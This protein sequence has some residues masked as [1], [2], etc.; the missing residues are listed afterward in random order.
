MYE[1]DTIA[2]IATPPGPGGIGVIRVSGAAAEQLAR[3]VAPRRRPADAWQSHRLYRVRLC[4]A[5][6]TALDDGMAVLMRAPHS[7]TG[8]D[9]LE[10]HAHGSPVVL[11]GLLS[12][13]LELGARPARAGEFTQ[14]AFLNGKLDLAQAEAVMALV[15]ARTADG[16]AAAAGQLF[17]GLSA[18]CAA[19]RACL[20]RARAH[21]E[22]CLDFG[23][24]GLGIDDDALAVELREA[25]AA[26]RELLAG[27]TR[28]ELVRRG[29]RV[30]ITGRPNAGKSSLLN[31]LCGSERAIVSA[32][33][34]T[35][36]D[37]IEA[38]ADFDGV[39]VTL[40]D[41]AGLRVAQDEVERLG[42]ARAEAAAALADVVLVVLDRTCGF[43]EQRALPAEDRV[44]VINKSDCA[45][46]W[47]AAE[48]GELAV[49]APVNVA[50]TVPIGLG[51]LRA[52]VLARAGVQWGD[53]MPAL[54]GIRQRDALSK[55]DA[56][57]TAALDAVAAGLPAE[58]VAVD[59][60]GAVDHIGAVTG[61]VSNEDVLDAVFREFCIGK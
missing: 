1:P 22:A 54:I 40:V 61:A 4:A 14:R 7:Y 57:L 58:L 51:A 36:R 13:L 26:V 46:T 52:A 37:A 29:L 45:S 27:A 2:A 33:P 9:V 38:T 16:A 31:A 11:D 53:N 39:P 34:G 41:T 60:Q 32:I 48:I 55:V 15:E 23:D 24:E 28:G 19:I 56:C 5:D 49:Y 17:G 21:C 30:V 8:E 47:S 18:R 25:Q 20:V 35:T 50:A 43:A 10:L 44:V 3:R 12:A 42:V 59:V 6:G